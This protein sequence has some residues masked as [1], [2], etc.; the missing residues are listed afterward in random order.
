MSG[1]STWRGVRLS[2]GVLVLT[3]ILAG[4]SSNQY[5]ESLRYPPRSDPIVKAK[6]TSEPFYP[7]PP[8]KLDETIDSLDG[9]DGCKT[10]NPKKLSAEQRKKVSDA[11]EAIFGTPHSPKIDYKAAESVTGEVEI[12]DELLPDPRDLAA[13]HVDEKTLGLG[14]ILYRRNCLHC[15]GLAGDG[16]GPTGP[17]VSPPPRDYRRGAFKFMSTRQDLSG[18][19]PRR[20]DLLR[21]IRNGINGTSMPSFKHMSAAAEAG[22][23][24]GRE[25]E[26]TGPL[27]RL[28]SYV[29]H[30][31]VRGEVEAD[32]LSTLIEGGELTGGSEESHV[33]Y[34][35]V[36]I[37]GRW[38][39][40]NRPDQVNTPAQY[41]Y[42][43]GELSA[44]IVRGYKLFT[45]PEGA[46]SCINCHKDFG[47][48][49]NFRFDDWAT[50]VRPANLTV[51]TYRGGRRPIDIY[52]RITG[53]IEPSGM[54]AAT[55]L[56]PN[57]YWDLINFVQ[58]LPYPQML[59]EEVRDKIYVPSEP[60]KT[61]SPGAHA[62]R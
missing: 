2:L 11:L 56:K 40:S 8:G 16:R 6:P 35:T 38:A 25:A 51:P 21:V 42:K 31:S 32:T 9:K 13:L 5:P 34:L 37:L 3:A 15:H 18:R 45:N 55:S 59:P 50:T 44:S 52:W 46:A 57:E 61:K 60:A 47:R 27:N 4:C 14:S 36:L 20:D 39:R 29:I 41:P 53:G 10:L 48:Q 19:K 62:S 24:E 43:D 17:W 12:P 22:A 28:A 54:P 23:V 1:L 58:A 7:I 49:V 33:K 26:V 30:L